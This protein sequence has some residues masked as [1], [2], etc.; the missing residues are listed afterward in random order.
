M[1]SACLIVSNTYLHFYGF[2]FNTSLHQSSAVLLSKQRRPNQNRCCPFY[3]FA[4]DFAVEAHL[5]AVEAHLFSVEAQQLDLCSFHLLS[6]Q[7]VQVRLKL[8]NKTN[9]MMCLLT[10]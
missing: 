5:V 2:L 7:T 10:L 8:G 4:V 3:L 9:S 1:S 6:K